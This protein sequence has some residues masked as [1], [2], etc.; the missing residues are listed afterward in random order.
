MS[1]S[2]TDT[3]SC[4]SSCGAA[5]PPDLAS[6]VSGRRDPSSLPPI[7]VTEPAERKIQQMLQDEAS[8]GY[9]RISVCGGGCSGFKYGFELVSDTEES[10]VVVEAGTVRLTVDPMSYE[11]LA[12]AKVDFIETASMSRFVIRNPN[13]ATACGCGSSFSV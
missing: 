8:A 3:R 13:A 7:T 6:I 4:A 12:G 5:S 9:L 2:T 11:Y 1:S 10:D